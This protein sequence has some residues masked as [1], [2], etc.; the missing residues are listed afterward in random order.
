MDVTVGRVLFTEEQIRAKAKEVAAQIN[1][2]YKGESLYLVGFKGSSC[3]DG[4]YHEG[5]HS[6]YR[7]RFHR[8]F[9][10]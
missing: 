7:D 2:D 1:E 9:Q 8:G 3:M 4:G 6:G 10:L 5:D